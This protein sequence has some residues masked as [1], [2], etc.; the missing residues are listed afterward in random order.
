VESGERKDSSARATFPK[1]EHIVSTK[2]IEMLFGSGSKSMA[3]FPLRVVYHKIPRG[4]TDVPVQVLI[5][6]PKKRFKH[7]V[8]RNRVKRQ[9]REAYRHCKHPLCEAVPADEC[10]LLAFVW[11]SDE[12]VPSS[13][14]SERI[15]KLVSRISEKL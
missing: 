14:V 4:L 8:D 13:I 3:A 11:L 15:G 6:V 9:V 7:A 2:L 5:S 12:L 10:L 1:R